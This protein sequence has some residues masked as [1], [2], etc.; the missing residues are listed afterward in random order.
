MF[1][2]FATDWRQHGRAWLVTAIAFVFGLQQLRVLFLSFVGYL[3][4]SQGMSSLSLAP[5][6][7]AIFA[8]AFLAALLNRVAGTRR[9]FWITAG[10]LAL[11]RIVEQFAGTATLDLYLSALGSALF[12]N[13]V[14]LAIGIARAKGGAAAMHTGLAALLG[15][16]IDSALQLAGGTLDLSWQP[17]GF[18]LGVVLILAGAL[19]WALNTEFE[20]VKT[21]KDGSWRSNF[22]LLA[23]GPWLFLQLLVFQNVALFSS[24][25][26]WE[27]PVAGL[28][29]LAGNALGIYMAAQAAAP[30]RSWVNVVLVGLLAFVPLY[31][32]QEAL[33]LAA[34][35]LLFGTVFSLTLGMFIFLGA[36]RVQGK[37]GLAST[38]VMHGVGQILFVL[39]VFI[40]Y[41]S[42][43]IN[44]GF[45]AGVLPFA[46][47][48]LATISVAHSFTAKGEKQSAPA[49][50]YTP[51]WTAAALLLVP[52]ALFVLWQPR[53][54]S[55]AP[56]GT[57]S[58]RVMDYNLHNAVNTE[59][60]VD[61]EA[62]AR[63]IEE[64]GADIVGL[65]EVSRGWL[66]WGGMDMLT[67][68]SQRLNMPYVWGPTADAQWGNA[69]LSRYPINN[70]EF[71]DLP[72][73]DVLLLRGYIVAEIDVDGR[74]LTVIN[75]HFSERE[76]QDEIRAIQ[77][78]EILSTWNNA[79]ATVI[80]GD[81]NALPDSQAIQL[82]R[83]AGLV[84]VTLELGEQP[85]YTYSSAAPDHQIDYIFVTTDLG[86]SDFVIPATTASD[87]LPLVVTI[88]LE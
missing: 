36:G 6:A 57:T 24:L 2:T 60:R 7:I 13:Y 86:Y 73:E 81:L 14:P 49:R 30:A 34:L 3:R 68:L 17:G 67:W 37:A 21:V 70:V 18:G 43:D 56:A 54:P 59:G 28:L 53:T 1:S 15:V 47:L 71:Y 77:S 65:Q 20:T 80:M 31:M 40:F 45:R 66:I 76:G 35:W 44:F 58:V 78:S 63:V 88:E 42:F 26:G 69:I 52:L 25:T 16:S 85:V 55:A 61:P 79:P 32:M 87:H 29:L 9:A 19:I 41:A 38:T 23:V 83:D 12:L 39:M 22:A 75:T 50:N 4:D 11:V 74:T 5:I 64:S 46:A 8:L 51:A 10:G 72:P 33:W 82:M 48:I 62:I 27:T 84:D